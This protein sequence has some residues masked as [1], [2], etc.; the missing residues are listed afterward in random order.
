[1]RL[2]RQ[3]GHHHVCRVSAV[4][5]GKNTPTQGSRLQS[6]ER[7]QWSLTVFD[8]PRLGVG[9]TACERWWK[10]QRGAVEKR[11]GH[12]VI[13]ATR[14]PRA[15]EGHR[16]RPATCSAPAGRMSSR[17]KRSGATAAGHTS[18]RLL[19]VPGPAAPPSGIADASDDAASPMRTRKTHTGGK[20]MLREEAARG[21]PCPGAGVA[22]KRSH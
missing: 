13:R 1:M 12:G 9:F 14:D 18:H 15:V 17:L 5:S 7:F 21:C 8:A 20:P 2:R 22:D 6:G 4:S 19:R 3:S 10:V 16:S 11:S